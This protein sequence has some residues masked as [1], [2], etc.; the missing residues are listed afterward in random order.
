[1][2]E[3]KEA[4]ILGRTIELRSG[5]WSWRTYQ[6][7]D[8]G[9]GPIDTTYVLL[10]RAGVPASRITIRLAGSLETGDSYLARLA[11]HPWERELA[12][13]NGEHLRFFVANRLLVDAAIAEGRPIRPYSVLF[14]SSSGDHGV[15]EL[16]FGV[17]LGDAT[18]DELNRLVDAW[19]ENR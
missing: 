15:G 11:Q 9:G 17:G 13:G 14:H 4:T 5:L 1:M 10:W 8:G 2:D 16:P 18:D 7:G 3:F 12:N 6:S 19:N